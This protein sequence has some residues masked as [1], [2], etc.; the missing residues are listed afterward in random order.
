MILG[1]TNSRTGRL[2]SMCV[3][4]LRCALALYRTDRERPA[5]AFILTGGHGE[6]FNTSRRP[7]WWYLRRWLL[8]YGVPSVQ[9]RFGLAS[10]STPEDVQLLGHVLRNSP[11]RRLDVVTSD[12]HARRAQVLLAHFLPDW[13]VRLHRSACLREFTPAQQQRLR[14]HEHNRVRSY[15]AGNIPTLPPGQLRARVVVP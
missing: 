4:R 8:R 13:R 9:I 6:H 5:I 2:S 7:H 3:R 12:F 14:A 15:L 1:G 11:P 10:G